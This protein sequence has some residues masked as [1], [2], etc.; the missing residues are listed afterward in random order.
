MSR[1]NEGA[2]LARIYEPRLLPSESQADFRMMRDAIVA[3][4]KPRCAIEQMWT[5]EII[6]GEWE[7]QR[8]RRY[9]DLIVTSARGLALK[10]LLNIAL[11][12]GDAADI[13]DLAERS[14]T[15]K[16]VR[17]KVANI[18]R[19]HGMS[20]ASIDAEAFRHCLLELG[21]I[22]RRLAELSSR[23]DKNL[24]QLEDYWAGLARPTYPTEGT[25]VMISGDNGD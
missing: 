4:L 8:L 6:H 14:V 2:Q 12:A 16:A 25:N 11:N 10:N 20:E 7:M 22:N 21:E 1:S 18:L 23:R 19:K 3:E 24:Q 9:K 5:G 17:N 13:D 15:N